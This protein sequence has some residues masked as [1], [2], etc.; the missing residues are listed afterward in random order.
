MPHATCGTSCHQLPSLTSLI[1]SLGPNRGPAAAT[2]CP[3]TVASKRAVR[4]LSTRRATVITVTSAP[5]FR[6]L[7]LQF[8]LIAGLLG[9]VAFVV[10]GAVPG[11][12]GRLQHTSIAWIGV[13]ALV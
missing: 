13:A 4:L 1:W 12:S 6:S 11:S 5:R 3:P 2:V 10:S 9:L 8:V 7:I